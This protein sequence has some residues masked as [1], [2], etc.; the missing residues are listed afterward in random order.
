MDKKTLDCLIQK[1]T[2]N[3]ALPNVRVSIPTGPFQ[4][5]HRD[6]HVVLFNSSKV[7]SVASLDNELSDSVA[8]AA[9]RA[10][11]N[12]LLT[13]LSLSLHDFVVCGL[14][15][16]TWFFLNHYNNHLYKFPRSDE[17][18][19]KFFEHIDTALSIS[20]SEFTEKDLSRLVDELAF[21]ASA[22]KGNTKEKTRTAS[23]GTVYIHKHG[24]W[25]EASETDAHTVYF[26]AA[27]FGMFGAHW[28]Y[29]K[30]RGKALLYFL[31]IGFFGV[32]WFFDS[33]EILFGIFRDPDGR[34]L[35]PLDNKLRKLLLIPLGAIIF[36]FVVF[37]LFLVLQFII[38]KA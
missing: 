18:P 35:A 11:L 10:S 27:L 3:L 34:Y 32:G 29:L 14:N 36:C 16:T 24:Q 23:D 33:L 4:Q 37:I 20:W 28:F 5:I 1:Y 30:K 9:L 26:L 31:T 7:I 12:C 15:E 19:E 13:K 21:S 25:F 2:T 6:Y 17:I 22:S 8:V 38:T